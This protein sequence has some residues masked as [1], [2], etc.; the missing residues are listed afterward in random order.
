MAAPAPI[1]RIVLLL[2]GSAIGFQA[3]QNCCN[4][5]PSKGLAAFFRITPA[6]PPRLAA[7]KQLGGVIPSVARDL[8]FCRL[9][10]NKADSS[11]Q[12]NNAGLRSDIRRDFFSNRLDHF[13]SCYRPFRI[14]PVGANESSPG[15]KSWAHM[16][17]ETPSPAGATEIVGYTITKN[18]LSCARIIVSPPL[19]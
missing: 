12:Q 15:R 7:E 14:S 16:A 3:G 19:L 4:H 10:E 9:A 2:A 1:S 13:S 8:L 17:K 11:A 18:A 6:L 5:W